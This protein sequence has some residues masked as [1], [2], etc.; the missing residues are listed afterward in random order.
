[1][2][3]QNLPVGS[4]F[5]LSTSTNETI[6]SYDLLRAYDSM[7]ILL[8]SPKLIKGSSYILSTANDVTGGNDD[9]HGM[10]IGGS[11][12]IADELASMTLSTMISSFESIEDNDTD[13]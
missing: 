13:K 8:S 11:A 9:F 4:I 7:S 1:M 2:Y 6:L 5:T 10:T 3:N 12:Q